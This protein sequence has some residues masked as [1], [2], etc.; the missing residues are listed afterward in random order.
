MSR[1]RFIR[2]PKEILNNPENQKIIQENNIDIWHGEY[3]YPKREWRWMLDFNDWLKR[4]EDLFK[5]YTDEQLVEKYKNEMNC[6]SVMSKYISN[7]IK[8]NH[9]AELQCESGGC[10]GGYTFY[11]YVN[12][13]YT[14]AYFFTM[15]VFKRKRACE[16]FFG[17][18]AFFINIYS[19]PYALFKMLMNQDKYEFCFWQKPTGFLYNIDLSSSKWHDWKFPLK[20][21]KNINW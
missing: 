21:R 18:K 10:K 15:N 13:D 3:V 4:N 20:N 17:A 7:Y 12:E 19:I 6:N 14:K 16:D 11:I 5:H 1:P 9:N 2:I 8:M